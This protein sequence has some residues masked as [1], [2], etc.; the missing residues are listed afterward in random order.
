M[1][2]SFSMAS[3]GRGSNPT[4]R[5]PCRSSSARKKNFSCAFARRRVAGGIG[6]EFLRLLDERQPLGMPRFARDGGRPRARSIA[7]RRSMSPGTGSKYASGLPLHTAK[8]P[9]L[10]GSSEPTHLVDAELLRGID[11]DEL[12]RLVLRRAA[13]F[14]GLGRFEVQPARVVGRI[15]VEGNEHAAFAHDAAGVRD[16]VIDLELVGPPIGEGGSA[17]A[18]LRDFVGDLVAFEDVLQRGRRARRSSP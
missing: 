8:S 17:R 12:Q 2:V 3:R 18:V 6:G 4:H 1:A 13:V 9:S 16:R 5:W 10:P 11:R 15:G 7:S 14:H